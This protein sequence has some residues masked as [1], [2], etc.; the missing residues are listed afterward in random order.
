[1]SWWP[2]QKLIMHS[3]KHIQKLLKKIGLTKSEAQFYITVSQNPQKTM[4]EIQKISGI[5]RATA[6]RSFEHLK[7]LGL[8]TSSHENWRKNVEAVSLSTLAKKMGRESLKLR[9]VELELRKLE[10][11]MNLTS[12]QETPEPIEIY[13]DKNQ[14]VEACYQ[15]INADWD[16]ISCYG[17][18]EKAYEIPGQKAMENFVKMRA[19]KGRSINAVFTELGDNTKELL[20]NNEQELRNGK[21]FIDPLCQ[22]SMT[23][24]YKK[25][26]TIFQK[27]KD[28]GKRAIIIRDPGLISLYQANFQKTWATL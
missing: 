18:G 12:Y 9:K 14:I 16:N 1:M 10:N 25:Q 13:S 5:S 8:I 26:V 21:L 15:L 27:D 6:Y 11:L 3:I 24:I 28:L 17:S 2:L 19:R 23:Y 4:T 22:N 7:V 20:K